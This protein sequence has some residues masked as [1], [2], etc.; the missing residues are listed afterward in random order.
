MIRPLAALLVLALGATAAAAQDKWPSQP[1][2][3][4][5][6]FAA[7]GATDITLRTAAEEL[8]DILGVN[9]IVENKPGAN[10]I[11]AME[12]VSRKP[13]DG[14]TLLGG[15]SSMS[16]GLLTMK[17]KLSFKFDD[18]FTIISPV[19]EGPPSMILLR[20]ELGLKDWKSFIEYSK[21]NPGKIRYASPGALTGPHVDMV[22]LANRLKVDWVHLPQKG[23]GGILKALS[24]SDANMALLNIAVALPLIKSG[25]VIPV[26]TTY[27]QRLKNYPDIPSLDELGY[28][29]ISNT[30]WHAVWAPAGTPR[31]VMEKL[32][33]AMQKA[34]KGPRMKEL[35]EKSEMWG[36]ELASVDDSKAWFNKAM[37]GFIRAADEAVP[38]LAKQK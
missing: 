30:L 8:R 22:I 6:A 18:K 25:D 10:G 3:I 19:G 16:S 37:E 34:M 38:L 13:A 9:V 5:N 11:I 35:F 7:G 24:N 28:G 14:Y 4:V 29:G 26:V 20:K 36:P 15:P 31:D 23:G 12:E 33:A 2:R 27:S 1:I 17:Q 32:F 21:A